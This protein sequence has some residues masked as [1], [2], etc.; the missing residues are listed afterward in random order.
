MIKVMTETPMYEAETTIMM[1]P[2]AQSGGTDTLENLVQIEAAANNSDQYYK[3][4]CAIL[5]SRGL[6]ATV[7]KTLDLEHNANFAGKPST[8]GLFANLMKKFRRAMHEKTAR[9]SDRQN[10]R[11]ATRTIR[12]STRDSCMSIWICSKLRRCRTPT[13][14]RFPMMSPEPGIGGGNR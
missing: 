13:W 2:S 10:C 1:E 7:I 8:P 14:S 4:Q 11:R 6:A 5:E 3:T 12:V 9:T